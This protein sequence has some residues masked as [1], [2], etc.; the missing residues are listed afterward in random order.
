MTGFD[1]QDLPSVQ[2]LLTKGCEKERANK[3]SEDQVYRGGDPK[4]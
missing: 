3:D 2:L 1:F 4:A